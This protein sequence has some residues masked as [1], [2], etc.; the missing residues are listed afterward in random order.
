MYPTSSKSRGFAKG[1]PPLVPRRRK[2]VIFLRKGK[3]IKIYL[4]EQEEAKL[5]EC[6]GFCNLTVSSYSRM[7]ITGHSPRPVPNSE[8]WKIL[9]RL[10]SIHDSLENG[11]IARLK[12]QELVLELLKLNLIP[13]RGANFGDNKS[14]GDQG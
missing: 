6:A 11:H 9:S 10:Y 12:I 2:E 13:E 8:F 1:L 14:V 4:E 3:P 5:K 7:L